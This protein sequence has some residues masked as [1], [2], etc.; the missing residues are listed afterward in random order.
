MKY[1]CPKCKEVASYKALQMSG[2][3]T[4]AICL[5]CL[6]GS[7]GIEFRTEEVKK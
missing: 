4:G 3:S 6:M 1:K 7:I 5:P 2:Y